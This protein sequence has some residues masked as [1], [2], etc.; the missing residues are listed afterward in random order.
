MSMQWTHILA[1]NFGLLEKKVGICPNHGGGGWSFPIPKSQLFQN[2]WLPCGRMW[3]DKMVK[4]LTLNLWHLRCSEICEICGCK[5]FVVFLW[6]VICDFLQPNKLT[7]CTWS[8]FVPWK[9][10]W[11]SPELLIRRWCSRCLCC[12]YPVSL[13]GQLQKLAATKY[14]LGQGGKAKTEQRKS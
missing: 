3:N 1:A 13:L 12:S 4:I 7:R 2:G 14:W 6:L 11:K 8:K 10:G 5:R 9:V